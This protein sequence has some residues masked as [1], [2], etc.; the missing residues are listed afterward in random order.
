MNLQRRLLSQ[1][2]FRDPKLVAH[3]V[4]KAQFVPNDL[5]VDIGA[6]TGTITR[7]LAQTGAR[8]IAVEV[9]TNLVGQLRSNLRNYPNVAVCQADI[10]QYSLPNQPYKVFAN[11]PFHLTADIIYK[12]LYYSRPPEVAYLVV[13]QEAAEKFA[14]LPRETQAS[15]LTKPWFDFRL[16][17]KFN[18]TDF[19]PAPEVDI[20]LLTI[21]KRTIPLISPDQELLY[22]NFIK[23]AFGTWKKDLKVGLKKIFTFNQWKRLADANH[24]SLHAKPTDLSFAQ[25]LA[26]FNFWCSRSDHNFLP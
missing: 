26:I 9:D 8:V 14:G 5:I 6:G 11:L 2:F 16:I 3:L 13:Q 23:F 18:Q 25:W 15:L 4:G 22:K 21:T 1:N 19:Q 7:E 17:W 20:V 12:L 10:R 24:F